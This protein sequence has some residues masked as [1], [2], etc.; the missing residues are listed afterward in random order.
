MKQCAITSA[1]I[2]ARADDG[3]AADW[4]RRIPPQWIDGSSVLAADKS[5]SLAAFKHD[6]RGRL[7]ALEQ[8][9]VLDTAAEEPFESIVEL[10]RQV[11]HVPIC[12]ISLVARHRQWFKAR[13]GLAVS[14]TAREISFCSQAIKTKSPMIISDA[15]HDARFANNPLVTGDPK[16]RSYAGIP[17]TTPDG[18]NVGTICAI[19]NKPR[20]FSVEDI[21]ILS[22]FAKVVVGELELRRIASMDSLTF[23]LSRRAWFDFADAEAMRAARYSRALAVFILDIDNFKSVNDN[24]GHAT[25][26]IVIQRI[27][28]LAQAQLRS[29][30]LFGRFGGEEFT[31]ALPETGLE[32]VLAIANR[33]RAA[34]ALERHD[35]LA[36][37]NCT[38]SIGVSSL[39]PR[40]TEI[41]RAFERADFALYQ[42]KQAG[43]DRVQGAEA[44]CDPAMPRLVA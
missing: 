43:R 1:D 34:I 3:A 13:R 28:Q 4:S 2:A 37:Q 6:E 23:A 12:A 20:T 40:E 8:L 44:D 27:A 22:N 29:S 25:G 26:D 31:C 5:G 30:D 7:C 42:A 33:I 14:E 24:F 36:G 39:G 19:D 11:L 18:Y 10:V 17:L 16:I 35:C 21:A 32:D 38:V 9:D 15:H 41:G